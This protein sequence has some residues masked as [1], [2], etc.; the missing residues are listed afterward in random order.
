MSK[1]DIDN[2]IL[3]LLENDARISL[4]EMSTML[5]ID[6]EEI[7]N[8][9]DRLKKTGIIRKFGT[10]INWKKA[11][12]HRVLSVIQVKVVPQQRAGFS[13]ICKEISKDSRVKDLFVATGEY[14]L[15][16]LVEATD[17][18]EIS[19]FVTEKLAPKK[20]IVGTYTHIVLEEYKRDGVISFDDGAGR[21]KISI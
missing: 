6:E 14:D 15:I 10:S 13:K 8:R 9:I 7:K 21:L 19:K 3:K 17:I 1:K 16:L 20:D 5:D 2:E 12:E 18:D 11:G 4:S